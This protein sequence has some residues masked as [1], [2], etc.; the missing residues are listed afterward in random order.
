MAAACAATTALAAAALPG[1]S[2]AATITTDGAGTYTY[3]GAPG[4][5]NHMSIQAPESGGVIFYVNEGINVTSAPATCVPA[6]DDDNWAKVLCSD[7]KAVIVQAGD[8]DENITISSEVTWPITIDGGPG[9]DWIRGDDVNDTLIGGPGN[10]RLEGNQG[11]DTLD[12]GDGD[13]ELI[14]YSGADHLQGG[15][16]NDILSPDG[17]EDP[18]ADVVDGGPGIDT[19]EDDYSSRFRQSDAAARPELHV[20]RR[21]RRRPSRRGRRHPQ[22]RAAQAVRERPLRAHR[23]PRLRQGCPGHQ[24]R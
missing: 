15:A 6:F 16:G 24:R 21:R 19:I 17:H 10:D 14:G 11:N 12:G 7:P 3:V 4:E 23:G 20:R 8:G 2:H 1:V 18:S 5:V 13:D 22:R 9:N